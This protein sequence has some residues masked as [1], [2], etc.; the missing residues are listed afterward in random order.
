MYSNHDGRISFEELLSWYKDCSELFID[1]DFIRTEFQSS[2]LGKTVSKRIINRKLEYSNIKSYKRHHY[3]HDPPIPCYIS[4]INM[5]MRY[6][7]PL[8][9]DFDFTDE[10]TGETI[11]ANCIREYL[12]EKYHI[13]S[14]HDI[15][16]SFIT[17]IR[18]DYKDNMMMMRA[19]FFG[20][21]NNN[22]KKQVPINAS[23]ASSRRSIKT[24]STS[25]YDNASYSSKGDNRGN[26][27]G[28]VGSSGSSGES[29]SNNNYNNYTYISKFTPMS[30]SYIKISQRTSHKT[31]DN[32]MKNVSDYTKKTVSI[33]DLPG[34]INSESCSSSYK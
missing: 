7:N 27:K 12:I 31:S 11:M 24:L 33:N 18:P 25:E 21:I 22:N 2:F 4:I 26:E 29:F 5:I 19:P 23:V 34:M 10:K 9:Y 3:G 6:P 32:T 14:S 15:H 30:H 13:R 16:S 8:H 17:K 28:N 20:P 1:L